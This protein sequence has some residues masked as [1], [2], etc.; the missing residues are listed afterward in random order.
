MS[1]KLILIGTD[2]RLQMTVTRGPEPNTWVPRSGNRFRRLIAFC[3][4][5]LGAEAIL[6]EAHADQERIA[7]T[8]CS[9]IAKERGIAWQALAIGEPDLSDGLFDPSIVEAIQLG[10][11][12]ELLAGRY[13][14]KTHQ[15]RELFM[16]GRIMASFEKHNCVLAVVGYVHLGVLANRINAE[17]ITVEALLYMYPLVVDENKS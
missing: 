10:V 7:P 11:K 8:I 17:P 16:Y 1:K 15:M 4:E 9:T 6:E 13:V 2:H 14:M 3:I 5:R 12:P